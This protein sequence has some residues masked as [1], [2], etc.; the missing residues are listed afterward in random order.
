MGHLANRNF[1]ASTY[2]GKYWGLHGGRVNLNPTKT[3][4]K[5]IHNTVFI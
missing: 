4:R 2:N 3:T 1:Y 5:Y